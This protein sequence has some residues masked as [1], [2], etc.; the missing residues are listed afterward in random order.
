M[1]FAK[2][3][4]VAIVSVQ[5]L[6]QPVPPVSQQTLDAIDAMVQQQVAKKLFRGNLVAAQSGKVLMTKAY[7]TANYEWS[8]ANTTDAKFR[9]G[10][11]T[12]TMTALLVLDLAQDKLVDLDKTVW[13]Y[14]PWYR[15]DTGRIIKVSQ[16]LD[17]SSG[18]PS[19]TDLPDFNHTISRIKLP[20]TE[21][22]K[23]YC[24]PDLLSTPGTK[25][26]YSNTGFFL[27]G[28][29]A[30]A[31]SGKSYAAALQERVLTPLNMTNTSYAQNATILP[32][33]SYG[34]MMEGC[35][36]AVAPFA[37]MSVPY[38]AGGLVSTV[39]DLNR[40][41]TGITKV[42]NAQY[43]KLMF[44][45]HLPEGPA[46]SGWSAYGWDVMDVPIPGVA[47]PVEMFAKVGQIWG[48]HNFMIRTADFYVALLGNMTE[49]NTANI[50]L[51]VVMMLYGAPASQTPAQ[52]PPY[53]NTIQQMVCNS[54]LDA[55]LAQIRKTPPPSPEYLSA[56]GNSFLGTDL[57]IDVD[58][59]DIDTAIA[60]F[61]AN[62]DVFKA[63]PVSTLYTDLAAAYAKKAAAQSP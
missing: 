48:Y 25:F 34:Y 8:Q 37:E 29:I 56:V 5:V 59:T 10:S 40:M 63:Q 47:K 51:S 13:D 9:V 62:A 30:E 49:A 42:L 31:A 35:D 22:A 36:N 41:N 19:F 54:G 45:R 28:L 6:A 38:S 24:Q 14:L 58:E 18:L 21:F 3:L 44:T 33:F 46:G 1:R 17:H 11:I 50:A 2:L 57:N 55:A 20:H 23:R 27:L 53:V 61:Q 60:L 39:E 26:Y 32:H 15:Q 7:D 16:L 43:A 12:K 4:F 52:T